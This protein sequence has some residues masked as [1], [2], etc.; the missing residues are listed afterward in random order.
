MDMEELQAQTVHVIQHLHHDG[1]SPG[2]PS[3]EHP[4]SNRHGTTCCLNSALS[5]SPQV[6]TMALII[7]AWLPCSMLPEITAP[8]MVSSMMIMLC[9]VAG[10]SAAGCIL[11]NVYGVKLRMHA[12]TMPC[13]VVVLHYCVCAAAQPLGGSCHQGAHEGQ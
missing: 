7:C 8:L 9:G 5:L 3:A 2:T 12:Q 10:C 11:W 6:L 1:D 13:A 4:V